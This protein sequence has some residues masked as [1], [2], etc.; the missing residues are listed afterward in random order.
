MLAPMAPLPKTMMALA[1]ASTPKTVMALATA[2]TP[3]TAM[4]SDGL[5][6][7]APPSCLLARAGLKSS[8]NAEVGYFGLETAR[9]GEC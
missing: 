8:W 1:T 3:K 6:P 9:T 5:A 7:M 4:R 2:L